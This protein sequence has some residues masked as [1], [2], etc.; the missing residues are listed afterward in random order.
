MNTV[1]MSTTNQPV[2][3]TITVSGAG[4]AS[5][6]PDRVMVRAE[7][8][9]EANQVSDAL[10]IAEQRAS[11]AIS[12]LQELGVAG[13]NL[14]TDSVSV[15]PTWDRDGRVNGHRCGHV[16]LL[17]VSDVA[18]V[19]AVLDALAKAAGNGLS[20][21][22]VSLVVSEPEALRAKA[23]DAAV[24]DARAKAEQL[25]GRTGLR[26]GS[27]LRIVEGGAGDPGVGYGLDKMQRL[28]SGNAIAPGET[29]I[30]AQVT[31]VFAAELP[32]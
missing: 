9:A 31:V 25:A 18:A 20:V 11:E 14:R 24:D 7:V 27:A 12:A 16:L 2:T 15:Q 30:S 28:A 29:T 1:T 3:P 10:K 8:W 5:G 23:L 26:L 22:E 17:W 19:T 32:N 4:S 21:H 13:G 6:T